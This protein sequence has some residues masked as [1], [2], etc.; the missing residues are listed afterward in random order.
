M[1][2]RRRGYTTMEVLVASFLAL[3]LGSIIASTLVSTSRAARETVEDTREQTDNRALADTLGQFLRSAKPLG[4][5]LDDVTN[6]TCKVVGEESHPFVTATPS[7]LRF[8][9]YTNTGESSGVTDAEGYAPD[10]VEIAVSRTP[11]DCGGEVCYALTVTLRCNADRGLDGAVCAPAVSD[12]ASISYTDSGAAA[13]LLTR[14]AQLVRTILVENPEPFS[15]LD[16]TG[17]DLAISG[18][19]SEDQLT[20]L[21]VVRVRPVPLTGTGISVQPFLVALPSKGFNG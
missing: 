10:L 5:C 14:R 18:S 4:R 19:P 15:F 7:A 21:S 1:S 2:R 12:P 3:G 6:G 11:T 8:Y 17:V 13:E 16:S 20:A 9:A